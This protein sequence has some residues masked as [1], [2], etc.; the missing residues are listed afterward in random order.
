MY[1]IRSYYGIESVTIEYEGA[2]AELNCRPL[3]ACVLKGLLS[4]M[5]ESVNMINAPIVARERN[6]DVSEVKH[7]RPSEYQTLIRLTV[8]Y[9]FV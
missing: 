6:I 2:A 1:A 4:P 7:E 3:T 8:S 9:N 5:M